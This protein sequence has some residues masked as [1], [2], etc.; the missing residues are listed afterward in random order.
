MRLVGMWVLGM[1]NNPGFRSASSGLLAEIGEL[2]SLR[3]I[4]RAAQMAKSFSFP[5][6]LII[7]GKSRTQKNTPRLH[8][9]MLTRIL[10]T[11]LPVALFFAIWQVNP[12]NQY[13][14]LHSLP[15]FSKFFYCCA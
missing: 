4:R 9:G 12:V 13:F 6:N 3:D 15:L 10:G 1:E 14:M 8:K 5:S 7:R 11:A 2:L